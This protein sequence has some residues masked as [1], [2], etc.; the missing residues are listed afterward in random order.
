MELKPARTAMT[1]PR[2]HFFG[3]SF[4]F[5][6]G[7]PEGLGWVG[8]LAARMSRIE[9]VNHGVPGAPGS[10]VAERWLATELDQDRR[11]LAVF[12]FGTNDAVLRVPEDDSLEALEQIL[13][14]AEQHRVPVFVIGP[15]PV[16][17]DAEADRALSALD[18]VMHQIAT[19]RAVPYISTFAAL[20]PGS[21]WQAEASAGDG[22][23][24]AAGGYAELAEL[25]RTSGLTEWL[26]KMSSR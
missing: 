19:L 14:R 21:V 2:A 5:G 6:Q 9:F 1:K 18:S 13:N 17:D 12:C 10:Y 23:H 25:L 11:E 24:P 26:T 16:G 7:D 4:T 8:R 15:P 20:G 3:D 22:S